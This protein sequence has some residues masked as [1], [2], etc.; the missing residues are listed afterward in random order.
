VRADG[1]FCHAWRADGQPGQHPAWRALCSGKRPM[2]ARPSTLAE[3]IIGS[4]I[5]VHRALGPGL[6]ESTYDACLTYELDSRGVPFKR[7]VP[8]PVD[9]KGIRITCG[10]RADFVVAGAILIEIKSVDHLLPLHQAQVLTCLRLLELRQGLLV[11]FNSP[12]LVDGLR[13]IVR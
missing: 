5:D 13:N 9:Y 8:V 11:N 12:R 7:Q 2:R 1:R 4:A 3:T 10:Y 6:L